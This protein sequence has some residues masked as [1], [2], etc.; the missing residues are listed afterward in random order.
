MA[1]TE[2]EKREYIKTMLDDSTI[3]DSLADMALLEAK[4]NIFMRMYPTG[5]KPADVTEVPE[6]YAILQCKLA[7]RYIVRIGAEGEIAHNE[8]GINRTYHS[9]DDRDLLADVMQVIRI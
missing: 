1:M 5:N 4:E 6:R 8:N 9:T 7:C 3:A 2:A